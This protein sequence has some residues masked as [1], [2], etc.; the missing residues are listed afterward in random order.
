M[1]L[2]VIKD[3]EYLY[4]KKDKI[5]EEL[6]YLNNMPTG[7]TGIVGLGSYGKDSTLNI[8]KYQLKILDWLNEASARKIKSTLERE[9][10]GLCI[11]C[12]GGL[13]HGELKCG[14]CTKRFVFCDM[15]R[16]SVRSLI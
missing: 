5:E 12:Q 2:L 1:E 4:A 15:M 9:K 7:S 11:S 14:K 10:K 16:R 8:K 6:V 13:Y 3:K